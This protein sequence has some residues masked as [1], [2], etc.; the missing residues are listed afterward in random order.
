MTTIFM[1][2]CRIKSIKQHWCELWPTWE[3]STL[4]SSVH[5][6]TN[7]NES[8]WCENLRCQPRDFKAFV[9]YQLS[10]HH[11]PK[12]WYLRHCCKPKHSWWMV[13]EKCPPL[14]P[15]HHDPLPT[16]GQRSAEL[17]FRTRPPNVAWS[18]P[19][20]AS[21]WKIPQSSEHQRHQSWHPISHGCVAINIPTFEWRV[22]IR[23]KRHHDGTNAE[24]LGQNQVVFLHWCVPLYPMV[25]E[26]LQYQPWLCSIQG[27]FQQ[28]KRP[29]Q[30][31]GLHQLVG[32]NDSL[33]FVM[34]KLG[35]PN[36]NLVICKTGWPNSGDG[37]ELGANASNAATYN[38]NL[39]QR[40]TTKPPIGTPARP[41]VTI[42]TF[43]FSL[44]GENEKPGPGTERH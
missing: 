11:H 20:H 14:L 34:A 10:F 9:K 13:K 36:I 16:C 17:Q 4:S 21:Y 1:Q 7:S 23:R 8:L 3:Q 37:E 29:W 18:C 41:R 22:Q 5:W 28:H 32:P 25:A 42:T 43:I 38:R 44:F 26:P 24:V 30:W 39:I 35:Y 31:L 12:Q 6:V 40:M 15:Q 2:F 19:I 33:I 27:K